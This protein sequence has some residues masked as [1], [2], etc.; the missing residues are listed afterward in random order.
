MNDISEPKMTQ[1]Q[2]Y[3]FLTNELKLPIKETYFNWLCLPSRNAG[4]PVA[5]RWGSRKMYSPA[6]VKE[7]AK[8]RCQIPA[9]SEP[10]AA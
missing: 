7:W 4:P 1:K 6:E 10:R 8:A 2:T 5:L 9:G 3:L